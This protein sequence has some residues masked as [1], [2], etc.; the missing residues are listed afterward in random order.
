MESRELV[1]LDL[2][3]R[4]Q[5]FLDVPSKVDDAIQIA[6][7]TRVS[8]WRSM[9]PRGV[10]TLGEG[11][12][13]KAYRFFPGIGQQRGLHLWHPVQISRKASAGDPGYDA[14]KYN[15]HTVTYGFDA[16]VYGG[17]GIE[18]NTPSICIKDLRFMWQM[19]QQLAAIYG[20]LPEVTL[21]LWENYSREMYASMCNEAGRC[22]VMTNGKAT[23]LTFE[24]DPESV[25]SDSD[26]LLTITNGRL[27]DIGVLDWRQCKWFSRYLQMQCPAA[28]VGNKDGRPVFGWVGDLEDFD[29]MIEQNPTLREDYRYASPQIL[30]QNYGQT[31]E[32]KG[33]SLQ[34]DQLSPR[35]VI[36]KI[37]GNDI[38]LK[39]VDPMVSTSASL[40]GSRVDVNEDYLNA[41]FAAFFI[42]LKD[43]F[44]IEVPP[45]GP[46]SAGGGTSFGAVPGLNGEWKWLN[47]ADKTDNPL[48][49]NG[50]YFMRAEAFAKPEKNREQP[51]MVLYR[52]FT[53]LKAEYTGMGGLLRADSQTVAVAAVAGD[54]DATNYTLTLELGGYLNAEAGQ[55]V[56]LVDSDKG[57]AV[58][59]IIADS[60]A[61]PVYKI[62]LATAPTAYGKWNT[63]AV[64]TVV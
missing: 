43:V 41:E 19:Q 53:N 58:L 38:I 55:P 64:V 32:Y 30:I 47:I 6:L 46:T 13:K 15:P 34:H 48:Q 40:I 35:F 25:D 44:T 31:T 7:P 21:D 61:A 3:E 33:Y 29:T 2:A 1:S 62:A 12:E 20:Y 49:E 37:S 4:N 56:S 54:V 10:Y 8:T 17:K 42:Y 9:I 16:T 50:F 59:G 26:N 51:V 22:F 45:S 24:Y 60:S 28:A 11:L 5:L 57:A 18:Y 23:A 27:N 36:K 39:R 14:S 63:T 52:R